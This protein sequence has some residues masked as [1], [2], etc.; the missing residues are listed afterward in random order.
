MLC[1]FL[2]ITHR[3]RLET[4]RPEERAN[5]TASKQVSFIDEPLQFLLFK[6]KLL[7][8]LTNLYNSNSCNTTPLIAK[9]TFPNSI[10]FSHHELWAPVIQM[11]QMI[12]NE[13]KTRN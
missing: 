12:Q 2:T 7:R 13:K 6:A 10:V 1:C 8:S 4:D 3:N 9:V 5:N 11:I